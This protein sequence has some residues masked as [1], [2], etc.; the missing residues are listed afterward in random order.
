MTH[1]AP[2]FCTRCAAHRRAGRRFAH[3][4]CSRCRR[5]TCEHFLRFSNPQAIC[6]R[7]ARQT[8][9]IIPKEA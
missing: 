8:R 4:A 9:H 3:T 5:D 1:P 7:C 6:G 2:H